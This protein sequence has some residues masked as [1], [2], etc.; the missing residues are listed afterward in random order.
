MQTTILNKEGEKMLESN[1]PYYRVD[2]GLG[3]GIAYGALA[4]VA[5]MGTTQGVMFGMAR[6]EFNKARD[7]FVK[8]RITPAL[9]LPAPIGTVEGTPTRALVPVHKPTLPKV[10]T[11]PVQQRYSKLFKGMKSKGIAYGGALLV[12][13]LLGGAI[14]AMND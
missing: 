7:A 8:S 13:S 11:G 5:A 4:G 2:D 14:D 3:N 6:R 10:E 1:Q 9:A 12:G